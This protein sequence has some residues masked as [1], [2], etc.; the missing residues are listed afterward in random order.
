MCS[1][2]TT[3]FDQNQNRFDAEDLFTYHVLTETLFKVQVK[4]LMGKL[5]AKMDSEIT[6]NTAAELIMLVIEQSKIHSAVQT[7]I[8]EFAVSAWESFYTV[9]MV[10]YPLKDNVFLANVSLLHWKL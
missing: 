5:Q 2:Q 6:T 1:D 7:N 9:V 4:A 3:I 10:T 8:F